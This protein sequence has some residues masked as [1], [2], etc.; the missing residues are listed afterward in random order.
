MWPRVDGLRAFCLGRTGE[1]R[2]RLNRL[3]FSGQKHATAGLWRHE[4]ESEG[5]ALDEVGERQVLLDN[6]SQPI[7]IVVVDR[8]EVHRFLDVPWEFA[9]AEGEGFQSISDWR[10][11]HRSY[12]EREGITVTDHDDVVCVW[13]SLTQ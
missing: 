10:E 6:D 9:L 11:G 3:V 13:F 12:Y 5:E 8:V 1:M 2:S 4:Y 7:A